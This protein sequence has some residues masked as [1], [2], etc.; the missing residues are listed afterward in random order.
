VN[1]VF[2]SAT[3]LGFSPQGYID[4]FPLDSVGEIHL[5][6]HD[7]DEDDH[8]APLLID[9]HGR[10]V[11]DPVWALLDYTLEHS[12]PRP[13]LI[14]WDTDVPDWPVLRAEAQRAQDALD[15]VPA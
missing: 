5:G 13:L 10:A 8:G 14:E 2:V 11:V 4:A 15:R 7:E 6:G 12:G 1:N 3:N 9:S